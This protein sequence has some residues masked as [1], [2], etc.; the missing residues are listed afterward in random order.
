M[1]FIGPKRRAGA[2][3]AAANR[4]RWEVDHA[5]GVAPGSTGPTVHRGDTEWCLTEIAE[6]VAILRRTPG[7]HRRRSARALGTT[8]AGTDAVGRGAVLRLARGRPMNRST[9]DRHDRRHGAEYQALMTAVGALGALAV[10]SS[11]IPVVEHITGA[12]LVAAGLLWLAVALLRRELRIRARLADPRT[13]PA[14]STTPGET[15]AAHG[16]P[17]NSFTAARGGAPS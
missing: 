15:R 14:R 7:H 13:R 5:L 3:R 11:V 16:P 6:T 12:V 2:M 1:W 17:N 9:G 10:V 4:L 8:H